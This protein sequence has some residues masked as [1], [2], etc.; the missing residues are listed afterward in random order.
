MISN[1][2][3]ADGGNKNSIDGARHVYRFYRPT[4]TLHRCLAT[5]GLH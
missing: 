1:L 5:T 2:N 4:C 3:Q